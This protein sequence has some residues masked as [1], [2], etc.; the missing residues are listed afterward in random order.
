[1][2]ASEGDQLHVHGH[3]VGQ[4]DR[5]GE[6]IAVRGTDGRPPYLVRFTDGTETLI[7]PGP[8]AVV[9]TRHT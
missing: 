5:I 8:D 4:P 9:E 1:M 3:T 7:F 2:Q 6:I